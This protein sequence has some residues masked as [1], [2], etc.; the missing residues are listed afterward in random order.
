MAQAFS[1]FMVFSPQKAREE[2]IIAL[3]E[4]DNRA[5]GSDTGAGAERPWGVTEE[6]P[7]FTEEVEACTYKHIH[8]QVFQCHFKVFQ[9]GS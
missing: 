8:E 5:R 9:F 7:L 6:G 2:E 3:G 1:D 4:L